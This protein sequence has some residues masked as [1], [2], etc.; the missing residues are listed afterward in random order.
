MECD[1]ACDV[2]S[3]GLPVVGVAGSVVV[4]SAPVECAADAVVRRGCWRAVVR[5]P[6][7]CM[8]SAARESKPGPVSTS[9]RYG[10][11]M[12]SRTSDDN[13]PLVCVNPVDHKTRRPPESA[14][15]H[16]SCLPAC[17]PP[18]R[19]PFSTLAVRISGMFWL[20]LVLLCYQSFRARAHVHRK[21]SSVRSNKMIKKQ[22]RCYC[23]Q[24]RL[25]PPRMGSATLWAA[26]HA[27]TSGCT[28]R[29]RSSVLI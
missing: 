20:L 23:H 15:T 9:L 19:G 18:C 21:Q 14:A 4:R 29:T 5:L 26:C 8:I 7:E 2:C 28:A 10:R 22:E 13:G 1:D 12:S 17:R 27:M 25:M 24:S 11:S 3:V 16:H 6:V